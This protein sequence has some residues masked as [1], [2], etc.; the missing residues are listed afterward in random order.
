MGV[1]TTESADDDD[2]CVEFDERCV[3]ALAG[4]AAAEAAAGAALFRV[5]LRVR[6]ANS[7]VNMPVALAG[8]ITAAESEIGDIDACATTSTGLLE[9]CVTG[10][11]ETRC[12]R[13]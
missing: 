6:L 11:S 5:I 4:A 13:L 7:R 3:V 2:A 8:L 10:M 12:E 9:S 1:G